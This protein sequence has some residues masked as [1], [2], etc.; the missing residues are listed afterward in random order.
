MTHPGDPDHVERAMAALERAALRA[1]RTAAQTGTRLIIVR[2]GERVAES[3]SA[4]AATSG[5]PR[6]N[7]DVRQ[8]SDV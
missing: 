7:G 5:D 6:E 1:R 2:D 4:G 8:H 3:V